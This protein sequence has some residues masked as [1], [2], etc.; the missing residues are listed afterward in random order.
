M[1]LKLKAKL[2][3]KLGKKSAQ[4]RAEGNVPAEN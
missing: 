1:T 3:E 4:V 2:R